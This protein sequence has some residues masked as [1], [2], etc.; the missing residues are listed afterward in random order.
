ME[1]V[2]KIFRKVEPRLVLF[3]QKSDRSLD[4]GSPETT[5]FLANIGVQ[6][7]NRSDKNDKKWPKSRFRRSPH[8]K[9]IPGNDVIFSQNRALDWV[10]KHQKN[11]TRSFFTRACH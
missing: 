11:D 7:V 2:R 10:K 4:W 8:S 3:F 1:K 9:V 6:G 5:Y